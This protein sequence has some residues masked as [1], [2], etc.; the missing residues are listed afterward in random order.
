MSLIV[1][2]L[3][4]FCRVPCVKS[5]GIRFTINGNPWFDLVLVTNVAGAGD[6]TAVSIRGGYGPWIPMSRNWG[7]N[8]QSNAKLVGKSLSFIVTTSD[9]RQVVSTNAALSNWYFG[10]TFEGSQFS[11]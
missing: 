9:G 4:M 10:Q 8:W 5:G 6:V 7:Q 3:E 2:M 11:T 1:K